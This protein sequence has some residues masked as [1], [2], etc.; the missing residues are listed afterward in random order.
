VA[1]DFYNNV[2]TNFHDN[3]FEID[4]GRHNTRVLRNVMLNA[5]SHAFCNQPSIGGPAYWLTNYS[6]SDHNGFRPNPGAAVTRT[7][8]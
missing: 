5:A 3:P 4:G 8:S 6:S 2:L 7:D 1:I